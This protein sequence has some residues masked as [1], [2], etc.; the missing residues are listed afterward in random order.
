VLGRHGRRG[1]ESERQGARARCAE[2]LYFFG[3][4]VRADTTIWN[5]REDPLAIHARATK[6]G[7]L[8]PGREG[9]R[10]RPLKGGG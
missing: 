8:T 4:G 9:G 6:R 1:V 7:A 3:V 10:G 5:V 2:A